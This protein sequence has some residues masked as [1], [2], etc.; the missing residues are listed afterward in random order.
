MLLKAQ[1]PNCGGNLEVDNSKDAAICPFCKT[2]YIVEKAINQYN[3]NANTVNLNGN[4]NISLNDK[5]RELE[6]IDAW[7][8]FEEYDKAKEALLLLSE[9]YAG[10]ERVWDKLL[11]AIS[12]NKTAEWNYE[13]YQNQ[14]R[15]YNNLKKLNAELALQWDH[16][17]QLSDETYQSTCEK[18]VEKYNDLQNKIKEYAE[19][20]Q[21]VDVRFIV[22]GIIINLIGLTL[23]FLIKMPWG[24]LPLGIGIVCFIGG[25]IKGAFPKDYD[26]YRNCNVEELEQQKSKIAEKLKSMNYKLTK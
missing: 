20:S 24:L 14:K 25:V 23:T 6:N 2:P 26:K 12:R 7:L 17:M 16:W 11:I 4:V 13:D 9:Q 10:E 18:Y 5:E 1:C 8:K 19:W 15:Y 21:T 3:L 22:I